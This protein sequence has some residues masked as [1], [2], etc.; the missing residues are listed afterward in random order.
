M[1][2]PDDVGRDAIEFILDKCMD[3]VHL[4]RKVG[5]QRVYESPVGEPFIIDLAV[6]DVPWREIEI[7]LSRAGIDPEEFLRHYDEHYRV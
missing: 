7:T 1:P 6:W 5:N 4:A 3:G 2:P